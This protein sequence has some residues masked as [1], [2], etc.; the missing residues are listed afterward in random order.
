MGGS[1]YSNLPTK[2]ESALGGVKG[3]GQDKKKPLT[4]DAV[5]VYLREHATEF[6]NLGPAEAARKLD[7]AF[8]DAGYSVE[9]NRGTLIS[10]GTD[11]KLR[12]S[13]TGTWIVS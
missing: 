13:P 9:R 6:R 8:S 12:K 4:A 5:R 1:K 7:E 2:R 3:Q 11:I 10:N